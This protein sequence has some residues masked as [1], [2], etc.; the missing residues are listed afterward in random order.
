[1]QFDITYLL[2]LGSLQPMWAMARRLLL[3]IVE[4][5]RGCEMSFEVSEDG[6]MTNSRIE[7]LEKFIAKYPGH[8]LFADRRTLVAEY[9]RVW[10]L[11]RW[12]IAETPQAALRYAEQI[13]HHD[14]TDAGHRLR[15]KLDFNGIWGSLHNQKHPHPKMVKLVRIAAALGEQK[16]LVIC[17]TKVGAAEI[18]AALFPYSASGTIAQ[19][20]GGAREFEKQFQAFSQAPTGIAVATAT[21]ERK[22]GLVVGTI[23]HYNL[24]SPDLSYISGLTPLPLL[25]QSLLLAMD[26]PLDLGRGYHRPGTQPRVRGATPP[27]RG[28]RKDELTGNLF[29]N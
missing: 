16:T 13:I 26:H 29:P 7:T 14:D 25:K 10:S 5:L 15:Q 27:K 4:Q 1:M 12:A 23:I 18:A 22:L 17:T 19:L 6:L 28:G 11:I 21:L 9:R 24:L 20:H 2:P 3:D 8:Q